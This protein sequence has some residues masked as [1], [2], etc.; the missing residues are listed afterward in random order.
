M[1]AETRAVV[2]TLPNRSAVLIIILVAAISCITS[3]A[4]L[5]WGLIREGPAFYNGQECR[6]TYSHFQFLP[7]RVLPPP[8]SSSSSSSVERYRLLKFTDARDPRHKH[9]YPISGSMVEN[10]ES[11]SNPKRRSS[12]GGNT[13]DSST[14]ASGRLLELDDNWCLLP[15]D[16]LVKDPNNEVNTW[17]D[18]PHPH[19]GHPVLYVPG[20]WGSFSQ[21]RSLGAHGT[22]WTGPYAKAKSDQDIYE[23]LLTGKGMHD[24]SWISSRGDDVNSNGDLEEEDIMAWLLSS[25]SQQ[26]YLD[27]FVMDVFALDFDGQGA[28]LHSSILL[29]Q[30]EFF[31]RAVE[32]IVKGCQLQHHGD[33]DG[34]G[35]QQQQHRGITIIAHS[36]GAWVVRIALKMHP[37]LSKD[38]W[39]RNVVTLASP[40]DS[41]PYA[42]DA[43]IH[44][45]ARHINDDGDNEGDVT[46]VSISGGLRDEM[47]PPEMCEIIP[48]ADDRRN[49]AGLMSNAFLASSIVQSSKTANGN[50]GMDHRAIVWCYDLL[51]VVRETIFSLVVATDR[52]LVSTERMNV[53]KTI[54]YRRRQAGLDRS[55]HQ[56][57]NVSSY[58]EDVNQQ[59]VRLLQEKGYSR[60]VAIQL[61]APYHLN[62]LLKLCIAAAMLHTIAFLPIFQYL[63]QISPF[64]KAR[65][66]FA[67]TCFDMA[68]SL[69]AIP[70]LI[71]SVMWM[72]QLDLSILDWGPWKACNGQECKL[73]LGTIFILSQLAT[74]IHLFVAYGVCALVATIWDK[75]SI[76]Y[77]N[78]TGQ[79][80]LSASK[81]FAAII[82]QSSM[83]Q[84]RL[85]ALIA[86]LLAAGACFFINAFVGNDDIAWNRVAIASYC[87]ISFLLLILVQLVILACKPS[88]PTSR[89]RR[90]ELLA[91]FLS[92]VK[93]TFGKVLYAFSL[94][95]HCGQCHLNSYD[96]FLNAINSNIGMIGGHH[97]EMTICV[98]TM[99]LPA[100][101]AMIAFRTHDIMTQNSKSYWDNEGAVRESDV[102][103]DS[104]NK[105]GPPRNEVKIA[106]FVRNCFICWYTLNALVN[107]P[108]DDLVVPLYSCVLV[109]TTYSRCIPMSFEVMDV[110]SAIISND[111]TLQ[112][113]SNHNHD[114]K[115]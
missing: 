63:R 81:S 109:V 16:V 9:F 85:L 48:S 113:D 38:G 86:L 100:F 19:R 87:F 54:M 31:A 96:D 112:C 98:L 22:R 1:S 30:A 73:L 25:S 45:I 70:S 51:K 114:K 77:N 102:K 71:V 29:R 56:E 97:N 7:L 106:I 24:G 69:L 23:S 36:I 53:A 78:T 20:H 91:L 14:T 99:L 44:D 52:G 68:L 60:L 11:Q 84:L 47:I 94:T 27:G 62:S 80:G 6:M 83:Q 61:S 15:R 28:A 111:L 95:T 49:K 34:D 18:V 33:G 39:I 35:R 37:H 66:L 92:L 57:S 43:G 46:M 40:L 88:P 75:C 115:E 110:C 32:T 10:Y 101:F 26:Q 76:S 21:S 108:Q 2:G 90:S 89:I 59:H 93:A 4:F 8:S 64:L 74:M 107:Y 72:R 12:K 65:G 42:V 67:E 103:S 17:R 104:L 50:F 82:L 105:A 58:Q 13:T 41:V 55:S 3:V 79:N 5:L